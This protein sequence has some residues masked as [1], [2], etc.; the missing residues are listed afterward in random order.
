MA[1]HG[2]W[3]LTLQSISLAPTCTILYIYT[4]WVCVVIYFG[5]ADRAQNANRLTTDETEPPASCVHASCVCILCGDRQN[6]RKECACFNSSFFFSFFLFPTAS[7][8]TSAT[9]AASSS[10]SLVRSSRLQF[11][12]FHLMCCKQND[13]KRFQT[14]QYIHTVCLCMLCLCM[15]VYIC[16]HI[17]L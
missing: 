10:S 11:P 9:S 1:W 17:S 13:M 15:H 14:H 16:R 7:S 3:Y 2:V 12:L 6:T 8:S 4:R 5:I